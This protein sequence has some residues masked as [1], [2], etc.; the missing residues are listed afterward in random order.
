MKH[1]PLLLLI[2]FFAFFSCIDSGDT[3]SDGGASE[4]TTGIAINSSAQENS[5]TTHAASANPS[6]SSLFSGEVS[7]EAA[8][9]SQNTLSSSSAED[10]YL[11]LAPSEALIAPQ[12]LNYTPGATITITAPDSSAE[13]RCFERWI[14]I[15]HVDFT[16]ESSIQDREASIIM[17]ASTL[18]ISYN[19]SSCYA[20]P[21]PDYTLA[22][23]DQGAPLIVEAGTSYVVELDEICSQ[24]YCEY[25]EGEG[26]LSFSVDGTSYGPTW[27]EYYPAPDIFTISVSQGTCQLSCI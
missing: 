17:P 5:S 7:S 22:P 20:G 26:M 24:F 27:I 21:E 3:V 1:L 23:L 15:P 6:S 8:A 14:T 9:S 16:L 25:A 4:E 11:I 18:N 13:G 12:R 10:A 2:S 19:Y